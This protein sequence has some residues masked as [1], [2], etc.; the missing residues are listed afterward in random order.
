MSTA[1]SSLIV[2]TDFQLASMIVANMLE[3]WLDFPSNVWTTAEVT[4]ESENLGTATEQAGVHLCASV[5]ACSSAPPSTRVPSVSMRCSRKLRN[6]AGAN[7]RSASSIGIWEYPVPIRRGA[8]TSRP[9]WRMFRWARWARCFALEASRLARSNADWHRLLE[10]CALTRTLVIDE[11]G[12]YDPEDFND[13]LIV[14]TQGHDGASGVALST[15][16]PPGR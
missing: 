13:G 9:W 2:P 11:D 10:L 7:R 5:D 14:G 15:R 16:A 6:W 12:C 4:D 3:N 8:R 1:S